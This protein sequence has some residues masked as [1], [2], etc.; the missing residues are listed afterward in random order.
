[1]TK[2]S[3]K[4]VARIEPNA[5]KRN[6]ADFHCGNFPQQIKQGGRNGNLLGV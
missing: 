5:E 3:I 2:E 4:E 1:M 6:A